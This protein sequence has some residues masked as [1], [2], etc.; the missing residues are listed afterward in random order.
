[1]TKFDNITDFTSALFVANTITDGWL[2]G[3]TA[4]VM[5]L[6][7]FFSSIQYGRSRAMLFSSFITGMFLL[8]LNMRGAVPYWLLIVDMVLFVL[9]I[10]MLVLSKNRYGD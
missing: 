4:S 5:F 1:M 9:A 8:F 3:I 2:F 10:F 7:L 6:V